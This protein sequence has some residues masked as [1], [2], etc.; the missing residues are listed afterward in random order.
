M[1]K[2][3]EL[4]I[5]RSKDGGVQLDATLE[6]ET[7]WLSQKQMG[8]LFEK[9]TDTIGLH[10]RNAYKEGELEE[11]ATTEES[12]V[13]QQEG[14][15]K[16]RRKVRF[17][18]LD[19]II[20]VGYRVK[21][22]RGTEFRIWATN[23]LKQHIVQGYTAN[24]KRLKQLGQV[25]KLAADISKRK[26]LSGDEASIL[27]QTVSEYAGALDLLD[28]YDHQRVGI[29]KTS[30][31]KAKPVSYEETLKLIDAMRIKF[32][33]SA[34]FG[35]EKDESLHSSLNAVM[36]SFDGKDVYP[37]VEEKAAHLLYFL[38]KNHSFVDGNKRIA[39]AVFLR[40]A[41]KNKL[42][43]DK[44]GHKRI[45]DNALVAMTLMI[46]ESRPQEKEVIAAMLTNLIGEA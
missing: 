43:Y 41:E 7:I 15:R 28:D 44:E 20:S 46:A 35:K 10:I 14:N 3:Q 11:A 29:G 39:A 32:G 16:V 45:A 36:Q 12:S 21:S 17:Y 25:V 23:V 6:K 42:I 13:V 4:V 22:K 34:V 27:L 1:S 38:V 2:K 33:D 19:V 30:K 5:Y 24:E 26:A 37:S 9:D 8:L 31:R 18:N 40:F